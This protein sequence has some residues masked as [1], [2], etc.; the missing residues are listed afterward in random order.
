MVT[1]PLLVALGF[2]PIVAVATALIAD[3]IAVSFGAVG[4]PVI[5]GLSTL[6][7]ANQAFFHSTA[8]QIT[9]LDLLSGIFIPIIVISTMVIFFGRCSDVSYC[10]IKY[11]N[12]SKSSFFPI[13]C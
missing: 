10:W 1:A 9:I 13:Y 3:S 12:R 4:T 8:E 6:K 7:E 2:R 11:F 5:V